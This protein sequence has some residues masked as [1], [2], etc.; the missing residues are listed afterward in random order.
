MVRAMRLH[1]PVLW[2]CVALPL[3]AAAQGPATEALPALGGAPGR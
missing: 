1:H 2:T 3:W